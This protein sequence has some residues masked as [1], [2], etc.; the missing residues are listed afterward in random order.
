MLLLVDIEF[1]LLGLILGIMMFIVG[2]GLV[3]LR[4]N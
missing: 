4:W 1:G 3:V 2:V